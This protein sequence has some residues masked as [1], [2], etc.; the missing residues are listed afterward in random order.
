MSVE[1]E[2]ILLTKRNESDATY[3]ETLVAD[4]VRTAEGFLIRLVGLMGKKR[5][6]PGEGL[7]LRNCSRIHTCFMKIPIDVIYLAGD[8]TVLFTQT[9]APWQIGRKVAGTKHILELALGAA[10]RI[11]QGSRLVVQEVE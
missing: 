8:G 10:D 6:E 7:F 5:L 4:R 1:L 11:Q 3:K 2:V 9:L